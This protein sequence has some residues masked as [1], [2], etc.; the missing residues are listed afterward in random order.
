MT[1]AEEAT[2]PNTPSAR[3]REL[4]VRHPAEV[5]T[6]P[7]MPLLMVGNP[8]EWWS[9]VKHARGEL[10]ER[11]IR[12]VNLS[13]S[14]GSAFLARLY[15]ASALADDLTPGSFDDGYGASLEAQARELVAREVGK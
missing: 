11:L 6:N 7:A 9:I 3:L 15:D 10:A 14:E 12:G 13:P 2:D 8:A 4:L 5:L 1:E